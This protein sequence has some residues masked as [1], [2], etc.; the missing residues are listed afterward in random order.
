MVWSSSIVNPENE[1]EYAEAE[2]NDIPV[3]LADYLANADTGKGVHV[4]RA[5]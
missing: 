2:A 1:D 4:S 5:S 3:L